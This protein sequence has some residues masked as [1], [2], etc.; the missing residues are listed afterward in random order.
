MRPTKFFY[1]EIEYRGYTYLIKLVKGNLKLQK[2]SV[3]QRIISGFDILT[4]PSNQNWK[5]FF[6]AVN[7]LNLNPDEP[8]EEVL[9]GFQVECHISFEKDLIKFEI[10]NPRF[11][12]F[13]NFR[14]L[15]NSLT[16]CLEYPQGLLFDDDDDDNEEEE[17]DDE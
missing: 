10:I 1:E 6:I 2:T 13:E 12:N 3:G 5:D 4:E 17:D 8:T 14:N 7:N 15:V 9:D 11:K 16:V